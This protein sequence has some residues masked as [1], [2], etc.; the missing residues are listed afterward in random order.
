MYKNDRHQTSIKIRDFAVSTDAYLKTAQGAIAVT[1][2]FE[3]A[4]LELLT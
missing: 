3:V 4:D 1:Y 2:V